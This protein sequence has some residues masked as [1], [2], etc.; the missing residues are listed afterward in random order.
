MLAGQ[1]EG[2]YIDVEGHR[3]QMAFDIE[4]DSGAV[5]GR[6]ELVLATEDEAERTGG[7]LVGNTDQDGVRLRLAM[8]NGPAVAAVLA[9]ASPTAFALQAAF[10][11]LAPAPA[12]KLGGGVIMLWRFGG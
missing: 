12:M 5:S 7:T 4:V 11:T 1:W 8:P 9:L 10:G 3:G 2:D 6:F